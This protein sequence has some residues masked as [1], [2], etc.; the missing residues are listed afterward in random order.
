MIIM[1]EED[2][3]GGSGEAKFEGFVS[4]VCGAPIERS[5]APLC[6]TVSYLDPTRG[7]AAL[8]GP[9]A[10]NSKSHFTPTLLGAPHPLSARSEFFF[11]SIN[12]M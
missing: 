1:K 12:K 9:A 6:N 8:L 5:T 2:A 3:S 7:L 11:V 4:L 10:A